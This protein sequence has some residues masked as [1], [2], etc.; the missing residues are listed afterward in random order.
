MVLQ[1]KV[2]S[3]RFTFD[4][5]LGQ[6]EIQGPQRQNPS[7]SHIAWDLGSAQG[8]WWGQEA[9]APVGRQSMG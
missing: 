7:G 2:Q 6:A 9:K 1:L 5:V 3:A 8:P 4:R